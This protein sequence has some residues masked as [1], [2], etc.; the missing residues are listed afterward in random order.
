MAGNLIGALKQE[1]DPEIWVEKYGDS[2]YRYAL[3]RLRQQELAEEKVQETFLAALHA[4]DRFQGRASE[5]TWLFSILKHK[6]IDHLR[7]TTRERPFNYTISQEASIGG[8][9]NRC[10]AWIPEKSDW[11]Y[12]PS[13]ALEQ[14]E[15][16]DTLQRCLSEMPERLAQAF[17]LRELRGLKGKEICDLMGISATNLGVMIHRARVHLRAFYETKVV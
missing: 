8:L 4:K 14:K 7:K 5:K 13:N 1:I 15:F 10:R 2:L 17:I 11:E 16:F 12:N 6:I 9:L 3:S